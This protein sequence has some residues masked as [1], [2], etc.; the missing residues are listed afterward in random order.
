MSKYDRYLD[1]LDVVAGWLNVNFED[2]EVPIRV[3]VNAHNYKG[4]DSVNDFLN[5]IGEGMLHEPQIQTFVEVVRQIMAEP[6]KNIAVNG[7]TQ[8]GKTGTSNSTY[9]LGPI[10]YMLTQERYATIMLVINRKNSY[11]QTLDEYKRFRDLYGDALMF[12]RTDG[13]TVDID[14]EPEDGISL[15][16]YW[17]RVLKRELPEEIEFEDPDDQIQRRS[18]SKAAMQRLE[19]CLVGANAKNIRLILGVDE[20]HFGTDTDGTQA[21]IFNFLVCD[22]KSFDSKNIFI[23]FS[24]T[25][26]ELCHLEDVAQISHRL[27]DGYVGFNMFAGD[28]VDPSV[29]V[30]Q[31][32]FTGLSAFS[33]R[34]ELRNLGLIRNL[35]YTDPAKY[36]DTDL[37][38]AMTHVEYCDFVEERI[39]AMIQWAL[40]TH[41]PQNGKGLMLRFCRS[42]DDAREF[43]EAL[44]RLIDPSIAVINYFAG[45][46]NKSVKDT[47]RRRGN[48]D[49]PYVV[50]MTAGGRLADAFPIDCT[51]FVDFTHAAQN[52]TSLL[53]GTV[54]RATG[55]GKRSLII[56]SDENE[57]ILRRFVDSLGAPDGYR[58]GLRVIHVGGRGRPNL[59]LLITRATN[60]DSLIERKLAEL[61]NDVRERYFGKVA[62]PLAERN[63]PAGG[64]SRVFDIFDDDT[65]EYIETNAS[66]IVPGFTS[67]RL[68]RPHEC[69]DNNILYG[70][71][72][73]EG[74][75]GLRKGQNDDRPVTNINTRANIPSV[76]QIHHPQVHYSRTTGRLL[77]ITFR[78]RRG[79]RQSEGPSGLLPSAETHIK[80]FASDEER[81]II[82][83]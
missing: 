4:N 47:I 79:Y 11:S 65:M 17:T 8:C 25:N 82:D 24:A 31:P 67:F 62:F 78:C 1:H 44:K 42:N 21:K 2:H 45:T 18:H 60:K 80:E 50:I 57:T 43:T 81:K 34:C 32:E 66:T 59:R 19:S 58:T 75:I 29:T 26:Y 71:K 49:G 77:G 35:H 9:F 48:Q 74:I 69:V 72:G 73:N 30:T 6:T 16:E 14:D 13:A 68:L 54:G 37:S 38:K 51:Y 70:W 55:Y 61:D 53:Q 64:P 33:A 39:A 46:G 41:N 20:V 12:Q 15:N 56:L 7:V 5:G 52:Y 63:S 22:L 83:A 28:I 23:G 3:V 40:I 10:L 27:G 36:R 76:M